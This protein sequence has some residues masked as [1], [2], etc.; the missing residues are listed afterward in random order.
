MSNSTEEIIALVNEKNTPP[1][2]LTTALVRFNEPVEEAGEGWDTR[3]LML[4]NPGKGY[5]GD[6]EIFYTRI[7]L[8]DLNAA[9]ALRSETGFTAESLISSLNG[10]AGAFITIDDLEPFEIPELALG[11]SK[12]VTIVSKETSLGWRGSVDISITYGRSHMT[13][14]VYSRILDV[15]RHPNAD[16]N[17]IPHARWLSDKFDFT[18]F[19][20]A[21]VPTEWGRLTDPQAIVTVCTKLGIP[22]FSPYNVG[23][24]KT[25]QVAQ[26]NTNFTH[27]AVVEFYNSG[28][29]LSPLYLHY[30][31]FDEV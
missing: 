20:D 31:A 30:N 11:E 26:A 22:P 16:E 17:N 6:V 13:A 1:K 24:A 14:I 12:V 27:V 10:V 7:P 4:A 8:S 2:L 19:R 25:S 3:V 28:R 23:H 9:P 18:S 5:R 15:M 29:M 21:L